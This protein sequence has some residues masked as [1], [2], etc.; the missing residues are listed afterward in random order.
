M[1]AWV[2]WVKFLRGLH[3]LH[4]SKYF[5]RGSTFCVDHNFY[6]V[7]CV[8]Y[9]FAWFKLFCVGF[10]VGHNFLRG[11][12]IFARV[13]FFRGAAKKILIGAFKIIS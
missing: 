4:G 12:N 6:V 3:G 2:A 1:S 7:A 11:F 10:C 9:I 13:N 5:S 8:K